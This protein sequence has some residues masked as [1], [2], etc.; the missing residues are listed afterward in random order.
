MTSRSDVAPASAIEMRSNPNAIPPCGGAPARNPSSKK[1]K[2]A[3]AVSSSMPSSEKTLD[4]NAG[5]LMRIL[6]PPSSNP[7]ITTSYASARAC[8]GEL[9]SSSR[10][11][12]CGA[13]NGWCTAPSRPLSGSFSKSGKSTTHRKSCRPS[14]IRCSL[15]ARFCRTRSSAALD[16][17]SGPAT[18]SPSAPSGMSSASPEPSLR[19]FAADPSRATPARLSLMSPPAPALLASASISS[20]CLRES[21]APCGTTIPRTRPPAA[22]ACFAIPNSDAPKTFVAS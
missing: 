19:N 5:L 7:S 16:T 6:P 15:A 17:R 14:G 12:G 9:C 1:P 22:I 18:N 13:V 11:S 8:S 2:R 4:C 20:T 21:A 10:S 3:C